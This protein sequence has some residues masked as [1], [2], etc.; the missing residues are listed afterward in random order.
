MKSRF[1]FSAFCMLVAMTMATG[2]FAQGIFVVSSGPEARGRA[3]GQAELGG[4]ISVTMSA[5]SFTGDHSGTVVVDYG[6]PITNAVGAAADPDN[7]INVNVCGGG[8]LEG[9]EAD[10]ATRVTL[11]SDKT[12]LTV[13]VAEATTC[14]A[15]TSINVDNVR[16]A[17]AGSG[18]S[19]I[20]A[21][22]STTGHIRGV[23]TI[24]VTVISAVVDEL[25]DDGVTAKALEVTR[26]TGIP[27]GGASAQFHLVIE[28]NTN[29]S[30][31]DAEINL[32]FSGI[33]EDVTVTLDAWVATMEEY[34]E[35][36]VKTAEFQELP[37]GR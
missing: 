37:E 20:D 8:R 6:V 34:D 12:M 4:G 2:A 31:E 5:G 13:H 16:L 18:Q 25:T 11:S 29:D 32:E 36:M 26:H 14:A 19:S 35:M 24:S 33:P 1:A 7:A 3:N 15:N 28:E 23:G 21:T 9:G 27:V 22:V 30:F 17:L 10:D